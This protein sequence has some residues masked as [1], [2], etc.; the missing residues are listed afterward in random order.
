MRQAKNAAGSS[1]GG[2]KATLT[3]FPAREALLGQGGGVRRT[4]VALYYFTGTG[5]PGILIL[6]VPMLSRAV[7][8]TDFQSLSP[9]QRF[10]VAGC[11]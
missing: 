1:R 11:P 2:R 9:K 4:R 7:K 5:M 6:N 3:N 8:N 10:V